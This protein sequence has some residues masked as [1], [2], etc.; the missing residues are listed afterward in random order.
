MGFLRGGGADILGLG[1]SAAANA[2]ID[3]AK[4]Q[5]ESGQEAILEERQAREEAQGFFEPFAG[6][7]P[8]PR[9]RPAGYPKAGI[10]DIPVSFPIP[11]A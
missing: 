9:L 6:E 3:A 7:A 1:G 4:I 10:P 8:F 2:S 11:Q 5:A